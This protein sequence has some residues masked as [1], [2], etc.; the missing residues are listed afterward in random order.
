MKKVKC[1]QKDTR[2]FTT[3]KIYDVLGQRKSDILLRQDDGSEGW[4]CFCSDWFEEVKEIDGYEAIRLVM[5]EGKKM[6]RDSWGRGTFWYYENFTDKLYFRRSDGKG[7]VES[8]ELDDLLSN[9]WQE[10]VEPLKSIW[11]LKEGDVFWFSTT[12]G[13]IHSATWDNSIIMNRDRELGNIFLTKEEA[14]KEL[15][16]RKEEAKKR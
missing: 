16:R 10:Y 4:W 3:G 12:L 5:E 7:E 15:Q 6:R 11:D 8:L 9:D 13:D 1:I 14:E 2:R